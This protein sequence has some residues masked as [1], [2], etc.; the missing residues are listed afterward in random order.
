MTGGTTS[1]KSNIHDDIIGH[2]TFSGL[3]PTYHPPPNRWSAREALPVRV[4]AR[5]DS[6]ALP[7]QAQLLLL[8]APLR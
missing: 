4:A 1:D 5:E 2:S 8:R 7:R 3:R 6:G